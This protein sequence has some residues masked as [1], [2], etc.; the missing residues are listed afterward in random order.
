[1]KDNQELN[2]TNCGNIKNDI[3]FPIY[4]IKCG[5]CSAIKR[6]APV[7]EELKQQLTA[8]QQKLDVAVEALEHVT[9]SYK[10]LALQYLDALR[11]LRNEQLYK[12]PEST[13]LIRI[14]SEK[15]MRSMSRYEAAL[16]TIKGK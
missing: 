6:D 3:E 1:M 11:E 10:I 12:K 15:I 4:L 8:T 7:N 16:T 9:L 5:D 14:E 2:C 13:A